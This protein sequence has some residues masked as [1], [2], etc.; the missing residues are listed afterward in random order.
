MRTKQPGVFRGISYSVSISTSA[1]VKLSSVNF[2]DSIA[3]HLFS[4]ACAGLASTKAILYKKGRGNTSL[5]SWS[6]WFVLLSHLWQPTEWYYGQVCCRMNTFWCLLCYTGGGTSRM[7]S[8]ALMRLNQRIQ[9]WR[10]HW[11]NSRKTWKTTSGAQ[12]SLLIWT[13]ATWS[14]LCM[15]IVV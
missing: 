11:N 7:L 4:L 13:E 1:E 15:Y 6:N 9:M 3:N 10:L 2:V 5:K 12:D 8:W 14:V